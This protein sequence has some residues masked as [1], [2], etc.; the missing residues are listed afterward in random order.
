MILSKTLKPSFMLFVLKFGLSSCGI[1][2]IISEEASCQISNYEESDLSV[3]QDVSIPTG[4]D[5]A[6]LETACSDSG[7]SFNLGQSCDVSS[8]TLGCKRTLSYSGLSTDSTT[9]FNG[10]TDSSA[11]PEDVYSTCEDENTEWVNK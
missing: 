5:S 2:E 9:W 6:E 1:E 8:G 4:M 11:L 7:G 10:V 3:C